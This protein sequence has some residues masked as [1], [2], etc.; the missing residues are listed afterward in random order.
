MMLEPMPGV[1][2]PAPAGSV[3]PMV[4]AG[5]GPRSDSSLRW[6]GR[7]LLARASAENRCGTLHPQRPPQ[8]AVARR[9]GRRQVDAD[10]ARNGQGRRAGLASAAVNRRRGG[11]VG[12]RARSERPQARA[13]DGAQ[14]SADKDRRQFAA[15]VTEHEPKYG[16]NS[17]DCRTPPYLRGAESVT[18]AAHPRAGQL[19]QAEDLIDVAH[20]VTA[21][22]T[23]QPDPDDV[24]QQVAFGTSGHRGSSLDAAFN[25]AH[26]LATTQ[27]IA[28]YRAGQGTTG[29]LF[30]GRDTHALS[31][32]AWASALEVLAAND[33][34]AMIDSADRYTPTPAV[35]HAILTFNHGR[36]SDLAD[37]I[38][39]TPSH[40]PPRDGGFKYIPP[41][42][43][44]ADTDATGVIAKRANEIL[45]D[46]LK[47]VKRVP[48]ARAQQTAQRYDY[49]DAYVADLP[50]V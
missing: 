20:V 16:G 5:V 38:V 17:P 35:S 33:V 25:E 18:M 34:V 6:E 24:D 14:R 12:D 40:S 50:S 39:V 10:L 41:H 42:G 2:S 3:R 31:E 36:D 22:Y 37:G 28:E 27:A 29:P 46:G 8:S 26:I 21:Y 11:G 30:I 45:R 15:V 19:A 7:L 32:P 4:Y 47:D 49:M 23:K 1:S 43:G 48:L 9:R 13:S 44:P